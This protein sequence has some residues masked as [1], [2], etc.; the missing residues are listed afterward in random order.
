MLRGSPSSWLCPESGF[1]QEGQARTPPWCPLCRLAQG[2]AW[3]QGSGGRVG[4]SECYRIMLEARGWTSKSPGPSSRDNFQEMLLYRT[5]NA[6]DS[7]TVLQ[8]LASE[9]C[10]GSALV[11]ETGSLEM[12]GRARAAARRIRSALESGRDETKSAGEGAEGGCEEEKNRSR[13]KGAKRW[14]SGRLG[15]EQIPGKGMQCN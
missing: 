6:V 11:R 3:P 10:N 4:G 12:V 8:G 9:G 2:S 13:R 14:R 5:L 1:D 15:A 7:E